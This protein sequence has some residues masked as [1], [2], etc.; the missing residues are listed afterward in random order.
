M[1]DKYF[2]IDI[3]RELD[4]PYPPAG[5]FIGDGWMPIVED[6][7]RKMVDA[8]WD[9]KLGQVKEKFKGLRIYL[10]GEYTQELEE[11]IK[12]AERACGVTC[13]DCGGPREESYGFGNP[14]CDMCEER[15][16]RSQRES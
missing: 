14:V 2:G 16:R 7:L 9:K 8:G 6:A 12:A 15:W 4:I 10:D 13:D 1:N 5:F 11:I 3:L